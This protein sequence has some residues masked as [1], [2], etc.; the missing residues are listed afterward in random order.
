M[1]KMM[2]PEM[3]KESIKGFG[4][5]KLE[6]KKNRLQN[7]INNISLSNETR[8]VY[9]EYLKQIEELLNEEID[10]TIKR[11][12]FKLSQLK[13]TKYHWMSGEIV[14]G[15]PVTTSIEIKQEMLGDIWKVNITHK[16]MME[17]HYEEKS[18][19][20]QYDLPSQAAILEILEN[21][22]LRDLKNNYFSNDKIQRYSHWELE[23]NNYFKISGTFDNVP[24]QIKKIISVLNCENII[25]EALEKVSQI[26]KKPENN[27][28][29][30][31]S[32]NTI[33]VNNNEENNL[34]EMYFVKKNESDI[35]WW[36]ENPDVIGEHIFSFDK[37]KIYN[38]FK[39]YPQNLTLEE[40]EIFDKENP[41]WANFF[42]DRI[43]SNETSSGKKLKYI[44]TMS[45]WGMIGPNS[46]TGNEFDIYDD[47]SIELK[48]SQNDSL[49]I[50]ESI[51][52]LHGIITK[53]KYNEIV[54][55]IQDA[56]HINTKI[57]AYDGNAWSFEEYDNSNLVWKRELG[58]IYGIM[59]LI[60][61][62]DI[63]QSIEYK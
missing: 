32:E 31:N 4:L 59:P 25:N 7:E 18:I 48:V 6:M 19:N 5:Y 42:K 49:G 22:D 36:Y 10:S 26:I 60:R 27:D 45:N 23:Y 38:L 56:K 55:N 17:D 53:E 62:T 20:K 30:I 15:C 51:S 63:L 29:L 52:I 28:N 44:I 1:E 24:N 8:N 21:N 35:I 9:K 34:N 39:D 33:F 40:K 13:Y 12:P 14:D 57:D 11:E 3:F 54:N 41:Y 46:I 61:V 50:N 16:Y 58:Y 43:H 37:K 47:L 2:S